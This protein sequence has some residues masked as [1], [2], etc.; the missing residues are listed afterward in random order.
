MV[1]L[2]VHHGAMTAP[3]PALLGVPR[4]VVAA[5]AA[6]TVA[7]LPVFFGFSQDS[8]PTGAL[9]CAGWPAFG[10]A[11]AVLL[12]REPGDRIGRTMV[13]LTVVPAALVL[14]AAL[15]AGGSGVWDRL[16]VV[17]ARSA[18]VL[19]LVTLVALGW[20]VGLPAD[21]MSR[22]R[23]WWFL[24]WSCVLVACVTAVSLVASTR[25][26]AMVTTLGIW[27][28]A[29]LVLR[30]ATTS[31]F[32]PVDEPL[33]DAGVVLAALLVGAG[34]VFVIGV[35]GLRAGVPF[36]EMSAAFAA[37]VAAALTWPTACVLLGGM[38]TA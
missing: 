19:V 35:G 11:A 6:T 33:V 28:F 2:M 4:E 8:L 14:T 5:A 15:T 13:P 34:V 17:G 12:D 37:V 23:L 30:L 7:M 18:V 10:L 1:G 9:F 22:R 36:P 24:L 21:R 3:A 32:R 29:A 27:A 38:V 31:E 26:A 16:G 25:T 20:A